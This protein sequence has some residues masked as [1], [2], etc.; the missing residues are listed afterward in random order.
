MG[1][2]KLIVIPT[3]NE[4]GMIED[5]VSEIF[6]VCPDADILVV[7]DNSP[8]GTGKIVDR[9]ASQDKRVRC[10]HRPRKEGIGPAYIDGFKVALEGGYKY[11]AHMD[12]DFSHDP[13]HLPQLFETIK[14]YDLV[15]GSRYVKGGVVK[16]WGI[17]RRLISR[18]G[19]LYAGS[20][21]CIKISDLTCGFRC[22]RRD[23]LESIDITR[24]ISKGYAFMI[25]MAYR[26]YKKGF[27]IK[28][29]PIIFTDRRGG[30]TKMSRSIIFEAMVNVWKFKG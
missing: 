14:N 13:K 4:I 12:A 8:D 9:L 24:V 6:K 1:R 19:S 26:V 10:L 18:F 17:V 5:I 22:F 15:I 21:L 30:Q 16:D 3:Y 23:V 20:I 7:D 11:I 28:E 2:D 25:E 27:R 29:I